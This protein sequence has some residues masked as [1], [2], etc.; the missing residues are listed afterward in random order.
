MKQK[1]S[2]QSLILMIF[3]ALIFIFIATHAAVSEIILNDN[4]NIEGELFLDGESSGITF[5]DG[6][7]QATAATPSWHQII[8]GPERFELVMN[9]EAVLDRETGLIWQ[10]NT[11][12]TKYD[13]YDAQTYC[14]QIRIGDRKG[15]RLPTVD[16]LATLLDPIK[17]YPALPEDHPFTNA[18]SFRYWSSTIYTH[19]TLTLLAWRVGFVNGYVGYS[20]KSD[21]Y[22]VRAVRSGQ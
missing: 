10:R 4:V 16:E 17:T 3:L 14:Y 6:T 12:D 8:P 18:Q 20:E 5:S 11:S 9:N 19:A 1:T 15:W 13:W 7:S 2:L 22:Y 21:S